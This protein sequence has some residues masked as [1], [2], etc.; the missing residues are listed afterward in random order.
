MDF[1]ELQARYLTLRGQL[2]RG[3]IA[4]A[5]FQR[6]MAELRFRTPQGQ[7]WQIDPA[8]GGW[9]V[10][11]GRAWAP[12]SAP[13][14]VTDQQMPAQQV[15]R[16]R[17]PPPVPEPTPQTLWQLIILVV[18]GWVANLPLT[19]VTSLLMAG[20]TWVF[21]TWLVVAPNNTMLF[22]TKPVFRYLIKIG[23]A[24]V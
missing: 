9:L 24:H 13:P 3:E 16:G 23:R 11:N 7:W 12:A 10:W 1:D 4:P 17:R 5:E 2:D 22:P 19:I 6:R 8:T 14:A 21:H 20:A 18:K 15:R